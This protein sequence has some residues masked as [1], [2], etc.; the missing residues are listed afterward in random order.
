MKKNVVWWPAIK[1]KEHND[2]YGNFE[3]FDY[4]K[5]TW[6]YWCKKNDVDFIVIDKHDERFGRPIWNKELIFEYGHQYEKIGV[7]DSDTMIKWDT[8]KHAAQSF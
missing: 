2:K 8:P 7:I 1:N 3:Y 4:S 6:E 5:K